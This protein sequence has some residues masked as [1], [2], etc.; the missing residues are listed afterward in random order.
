MRPQRVRPRLGGLAGTIAAVVVVA[1]LAAC[2]PDAPPDVVVSNP[3]VGATDGT[4]AAM[5]LDFENRGGDDAVVAA[6]CACAGEVTL[7]VTDNSDGRSMMVD[8]DVLE[9]PSGAR[10]EMWPAGSH[11]MLER[12]V[13][14]LVDG[15]SLEVSLE[16][17]RSED[18][19]VEVPIVALQSLV[20]RIPS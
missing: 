2:S 7:H 4:V 18:R 10:V 1:V 5:Y 17:E 8:T 15:T 14:P 16:F 3:A 9:L 11:V 13:A 20:D 6:T 19:T 12:L